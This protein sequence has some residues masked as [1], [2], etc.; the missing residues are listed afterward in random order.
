MAIKKILILAFLILGF[1][2]KAGSDN[3]ADSLYQVIHSP[4]KSELEKMH[5]MALLS[6]ELIPLDM[7]S[8]L[9]LLERSSELASLDDHPV[10]RAAWLVISG[11]FNWYNRNTDSAMVNYHIVYAMDEP[12]ILNRRGASAVNL[13]AL[14]NRK[15]ETDSAMYF[16]N[17]AIAIFSELED[18]AGLAHANY[19]LGIFYN[20]RNNYELA[21]RHILSALDYREKDGDPFHLIHTYITMGNIY[22]S[23]GEKEKIFEYY[24]K[25]LQLTE[26]LPNHPMVGSIY[27]NLVSYYTVHVPNYEKAKHYAEKGIQASIEANRTE[28]LYSIY[29]NLGILYTDM[30]RYEEAIT[31]F[32]KTNE[33]EDLATPELKAASRYNQGR[34][35]RQLN[36]HQK[37]RNLLQEAIDYSN[38][39]GSRKW[40]SF[41]HNELFKIDSITGNYPRAISHLQESTR[42]RDSIWQKERMDRINELNII[43]EADKKETENRLLKE[44]NILKEQVIRN[45]RTLVIL[46]VSFSLLLM[47]FLVSIWISR[48]R[49]QNQKKEL[50]LLHQNILEKQQEISAQNKLLDQK[51]KELEELIITKDKFFSI[52][53]HD[54]KGP[55]NSLIGFLNILVEDGNKLEDDKKNM[56][57]KNLQQISVRTYEMLTN[58]LE[59]SS[60]Q[61]KRIMN[62]P[63]Q[64]FIRSL[65]QECLLV[66][67]YNI[68]KKEHD[69]INEVDHLLAVMVD[70]RLLRSILI[71]LINNAVKFTYRGGEIT[72]RAKID[73]DAGL[74]K[75]SVIDNGIG[76]PA[77]Q[78]DTLFDLGS[79][80]RQPG[81]EKEIG[82]GLGLITVKELLQVMGGRIEVI[83]KPDE[84][85]TFIIFIP[86]T[87][88]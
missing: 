7:D 39:A 44:S 78:I 2:L 40:V 37:A 84:G 81:T 64:T 19:T 9:V 36:Q 54:L 80:Y 74:L 16:Y 3:Y 1:T 59:W 79:K 88:E 6:A 15:V 13:A 63:E 28:I 29:S 18:E 14:Y 43:Y 49:I 61:R 70:P 26:Q 62:K 76:I 65:I 51:N 24:K 45:Q 46:S 33:L 38:I 73:D 72:I 57:I 23:L 31:W 87:R 35:Y 58:L 71:N 75:V 86:C 20:R 4:Q 66:L 42:Q 17:S 11:N 25:S 67:N 69:V 60:I 53:S 52:I 85:S 50:E 27:N 83:S 30:G 12:G 68:E 34:L 8:A 77:D 10:E 32:E 5:A 48:R 22:L 47:L 56:I 41:A 21:L 55:F 82:T